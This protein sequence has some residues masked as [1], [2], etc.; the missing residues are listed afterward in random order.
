[1]QI[2]AMWNYSIDLNLLYV[3]LL[4]CCKGD[5]NKAIELLY[6]F[7]K[8]KFQDNNKQKY[9]KR[10]NEFLKRR[11]CN[12]NINLFCIFRAEMY[13]GRTAIEHATLNIVHN[14]LPFVEKDKKSLN[15]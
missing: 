7:K 13:E 9:K 3:A 14:G 11:C 4:Y 2:S 5:I 12:H 10:K 1:M 6:E 15:L 8:W